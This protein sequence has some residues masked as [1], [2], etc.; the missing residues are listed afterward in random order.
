MSGYLEMTE[1][2]YNDAYPTC[3]ETYVTLRVS[4]A[5]LDMELVTRSLGMEPS[6][7]A[8][9]SQ[10]GGVPC[11]WMLTSKNSVESLDARRHLDWLLGMLSGKAESLRVLRDR[12]LTVDVC[13]YWRSGDGHGG[14]TLSPK[15]MR[16]LGDLNLDLWFDFY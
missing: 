10:S 12:D 15:Q 4:S 13:C 14:P 2:D 8:A 3:E 9:D 1:S 7:S 6:P 5:A 11:R 16:A